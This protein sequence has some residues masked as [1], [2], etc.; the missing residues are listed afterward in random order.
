[1]ALHQAASSGTSDGSIGELATATA[2][3]TAARVDLV[4]VRAELAASLA[5][6]TAERTAARADLVAGHIKRRHAEELR[7][8][9]STKFKMN[10]NKVTR[11]FVIQRKQTPSAAA[12]RS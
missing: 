12:C 5:T 4:A 11:R 2:E 9:T 1:M 3:R 7:L 10:R 8:T 6:A